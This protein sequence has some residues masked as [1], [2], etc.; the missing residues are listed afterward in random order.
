M[1]RFLVEEQPLV[2]HRVTACGRHGAPCSRPA[3]LH[4]VWRSGH[5]LKLPTHLLSR[6][7]WAQRL[8]S[9]PRVPA[10]TAPRFCRASTHFHDATQSTLSLLSF[11][12]FLHVLVPNEAAMQT[13]L[14]MR[15]LIEKCRGSRGEQKLVLLQ[16]TQVQIAVFCTNGIGSA[17]CIGGDARGIAHSFR[18]SPVKLTRGFKRQVMASPGQARRGGFRSGLTDQGQ[19]QQ[20]LLVH[21]PMGT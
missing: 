19:Q 8:C 10:V 3:S 14:A 21:R 12:T 1:R 11:M 7:L 4:A 20:L 17:G 13:F 5:Q 9:P 16:R 6:R 15:L 18:I 2:A